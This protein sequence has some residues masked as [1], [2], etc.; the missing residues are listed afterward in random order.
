MIK[1]VA[2]NTA[3]SA[4]HTNSMVNAINSMQG[5]E[6]SVQPSQGRNPVPSNIASAVTDETETLERGE[7][8]VL[9][10]LVYGNDDKPFEQFSKKTYKVSRP[11]KDA[12]MSNKLGILMGR[13]TST[14]KVADVMLAGNVL[15]QMKDTEVVFGE[16]IVYGAYDASSD[17]PWKLE[18]SLVGGLVDVLWH[19]GDADGWALVR[20][21]STISHIPMVFK[22][23]ANESNGEVTAS[24]FKID[25][26]LVGEEVTFKVLPE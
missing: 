10:E 11:V 7:V 5:Q 19:N 8:V 23:T 14:K 1:K 12:P 9:E 15:V 2:P 16:D 26:T 6:A 18:T 4:S 24:A 17:T 22:A 21:P 25:G 20:F 3:L 13:L